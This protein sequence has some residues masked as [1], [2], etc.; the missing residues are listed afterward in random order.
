MIFPSLILDSGATFLYNKYVKKATKGAPGTYIKDKKKIDFSFYDGDI[1]KEFREGY[2]KFVKK[3]DKYLYAYVN[4]DMINNAEGSYK[5]LKYMEKR[6][7]HPL[8]V[9]HLGNDT[10]WLERYVKE[11]Y[12][13]IC[14]GGITPNP[15]TTLKPV[16][17]RI[18]KNILTDGQGMPIV[19]VHGL[20]C[21]AY[22]LL[23]RYPWYSVDSATWIKLGAWGGI[24]V[25]RKIGGVFDFNKKPFG[26]QVSEKSSSL[27]KSGAHL[28]TMV[29]GESTH[30]EE[31]LRFIDIPLGDVRI[32]ERLINRPSLIPLS[33]KI[34]YKED[35][36]IGVVNDYEYRMKANLLFYQALCDFLPKWPWAFAPTLRKGLF[37]DVN[38]PGF[39]GRD[40]INET[41][42]RLRSLIFYYSGSRSKY[43][44]PEDL[45]AHKEAGF[46]LTYSDFFKKKGSE[47]IRRFKQHKERVKKHGR[48]K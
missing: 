29:E 26:I 45:L 36:K 10:E 33:T 47:A 42:K 24:Y 34:H 31:W 9:F 2:I 8:P 44:S 27:G 4:M 46:M 20:A 5:S 22:Q 28:N 13:F 39:W 38:H 43:V 14:I 21:T 41:W 17:D 1:F 6:G 23:I 15:Y 25:P 48:K 35:A 3:N 16:L 19:K 18:W 7:C 30:I 40:K 37:Q 11:G 12:K 32:P